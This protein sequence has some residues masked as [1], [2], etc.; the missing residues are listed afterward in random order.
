MPTHAQARQW[1]S[2]KDPVHGWDHV[3]R[4]CAL[5]ERLAREEGADVDLVRAA[6]LLHD[7]TGA[8]PEVSE[9]RAGGRA[10][11]E[12]ASAEFARRQLAEEGWSE[13]RIEAVLHCIRAHRFR[14]SEPPASLEARVLFDADKLDV[15]GAFG[16]ARTIAYAVQ[17]GMP[18]YAKPSEQFLAT[19][20]TEPGE[21]HSAYHE[22][23]FKLRHIWDRLHT[24]AARR[25]GQQRQAVLIGFFEAL[26]AEAVLADAPADEA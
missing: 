16:A 23:R 6:A 12:L 10:S 20:E 3:Q 18:I 9:E 1:Y 22:Y 19:G 7:V 26:A 5:A 11:H 25:V 4:V 17:D 21:P 8:A 14:S 2:A 15:L 24:D 13:P